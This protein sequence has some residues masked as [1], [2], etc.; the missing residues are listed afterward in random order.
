M[1]STDG[2]SEAVDMW[3]VGSVTALLLSGSI[4]F[5]NGIPNNGLEFAQAA[6][7][8]VHAQQDPIISA[9]KK[10]DLSRMDYGSEW[11]CVGR[12]P[13]DF[14]RRLL[15]LDESQRMTAPQALEHKWFTNKHYKAEYENLYERVVESWKPR[16]K[17][18][19]PAEYLGDKNF[20]KSRSEIRKTRSERM[21]SLD[22]LSLEHMRSQTPPGR[23]DASSSEHVPYVNLFEEHSQMRANLALSVQ[24]PHFLR[25]IESI[26]TRRQ[27]P[28]S[29]ETQPRI[30]STATE[31]IPDTPQKNSKK[32]Q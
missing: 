17:I 8:N 1:K 28:A 23:G 9:A 16:E 26:A 2:Y 21:S 24:S 30:D 22:E 18:F 4:I 10:C 27:D 19:R 6:G 3:S 32:R 20:R 11:V 14:I 31:C 15:V 7:H 5:A 29:Q 13:K 12:R 25:G